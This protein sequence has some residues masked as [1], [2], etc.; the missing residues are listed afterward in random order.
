[1]D[2]RPRLSALDRSGAA[3]VDS[4]TG[5]DDG[6]CATVVAAGPVVVDAARVVAPCGPGTNGMGGSREYAVVR[7]ARDASKPVDRG[8]ARG[9][10]GGSARIGTDPTGE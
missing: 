5:A 9:L 4:R 1:S 8:S 2:G 6:G 7:T 10:D 3:L